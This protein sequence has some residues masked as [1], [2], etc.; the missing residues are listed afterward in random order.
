MSKRNLIIVIVIVAIIRAVSILR[1]AFHQE[2]VKVQ[3]E[4]TGEMLVEY[5]E[6]QLIDIKRSLQKQKQQIIDDFTLEETKK[7][8][9]GD[10]SGL[11]F[12]NEKIN[13]IDKLIKQAKQKQG[14]DYLLAPTV[15]AWY[16]K[17]TEISWLKV[18]H[19]WYPLDNRTQK[20]VNYAYNISNWSLDFIAT[21][22]QEN[23]LR[24]MKRQSLVYD[25]FWRE[26]SRWFCQVNRYYH[27][28]IVNDERFFTDWEWQLDK[29]RELYKW[30]TKMFG[31]NKRANSY[32]RFIIN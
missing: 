28:E 4:W 10:E 17:P 19:K 27:P 18:V 6:W 22:D 16:I 32:S 26:D 7:Y 21:L 2:T 23:W 15:S 13:W 1:N 31:Y 9:Q 11:K 12:I 29:C 14:L 3:S 25:K 24:D 30:G 8:L 20:Y 5:T